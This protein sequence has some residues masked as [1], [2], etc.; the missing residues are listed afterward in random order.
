MNPGKIT[1][2]LA[3]RIFL[4]EMHKYLFDQSS[5]YFKIAGENDKEMLLRFAENFDLNADLW[6]RFE[7]Q[8]RRDIEMQHRY[9]WHHFIPVNADNMI[10]TSFMSMYLA[11]ILGHNKQNIIYVGEAGKLH[12][13]GKGE[14]PDSVLFKLGKLTPEER[15]W[16]RGHSRDGARIV[17][18]SRESL[19]KSKPILEDCIEKHHVWID[20]DKGMESVVN[21][22]PLTNPPGEFPRIIAATDA[23]TSM[24]Y[25]RDY[26]R[27]DHYLHMKLDEQTIFDYAKKE[28]LRE[29]ERSELNP[30]GIHF[31]RKIVELLLPIIEKM[32][33]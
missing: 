6:I 33:S 4:N 22:Y 31:D 25:K 2:N 30:H 26:M 20:V 9:E 15:A 27:Y 1:A 28:L 23:L 32:K 11:H 10:A 7:K 24:L 13:I 21:S 3:R 14:S 17:K 5:I 18:K 8:R 12:D 16:M 19:K 29:S